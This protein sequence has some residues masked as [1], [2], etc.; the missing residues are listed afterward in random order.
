MRLFAAVGLPGD[1]KVFM[2]LAKTFVVPA[3]M[4]VCADR[5]CHR[6]RN[7]AAIFSLVKVLAQRNEQAVGRRPA[8]A[9]LKHA[10]APIYF[11]LQHSLKTSA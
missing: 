8:F 4:R 3:I 9:D 5:E 6:G 10:I 7:P 1:Q 11:R 2:R